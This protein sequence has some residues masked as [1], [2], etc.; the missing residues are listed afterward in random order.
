MLRII[1]LIIMVIKLCTG[2]LIGDEVQHL[3]G[4]YPT[5]ILEPT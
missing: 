5:G 1:L 3:Q 4:S 2:P